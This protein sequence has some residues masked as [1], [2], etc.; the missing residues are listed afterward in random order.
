MTFS[1]TYLQFLTDDL[2]TV[3]YIKDGRGVLEAG[4]RVEYDV[5]KFNMKETAETRTMIEQL[6]AE[7]TR[8]NAR[9]YNA[10]KFRLA[11]HRWAAGEVL[12]RVGLT[13]YKDHVGTNLS[14]RVHDYINISTEED[15]QSEVCIR[16]LLQA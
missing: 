15:T 2:E 5:E 13:D 14:P 1:N 7:R 4:V 3:S 11:S 12:L 9:I 16:K 8:S 10:S 6:W